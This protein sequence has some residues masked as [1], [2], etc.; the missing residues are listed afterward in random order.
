MVKQPYSPVPST[1]GNSTA[2]DECIPKD[3]TRCP[4][5]MRDIILDCWDGGVDV[6][7]ILRQLKQITVSLKA[8]CS[9]FYSRY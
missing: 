4:P 7:Y 5:I 9:S 6:D 1:A 2:A 3:D 8:L